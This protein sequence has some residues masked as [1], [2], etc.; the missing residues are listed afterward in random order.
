MNDNR[1]KT[2][3]NGSNLT[4]LLRNEAGCDVAEDS[5]TP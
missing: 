3:P 1:T 5:D 4:N 2:N